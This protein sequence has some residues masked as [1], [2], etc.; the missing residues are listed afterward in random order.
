MKSPAISRISWLKITPTFQ[1]PSLSPRMPMMGT[2]MIPET[3]VIFSRL[4]RTVAREDSNFRHLESV[5]SYYNVNHGGD[6]PW[7]S[8]DI[9]FV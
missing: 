2:V 5:M 7:H 1:G 6:E 4:T 3:S 9:P 8:I